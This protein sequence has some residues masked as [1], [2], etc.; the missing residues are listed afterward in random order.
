[1]VDRSE[2]AEGKVKEVAGKMTGNDELES[3][4]RT[5]KATEDTKENI[6]ELGDKVKGTAEGVKEKFQDR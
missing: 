5:Q 1:M 2:Q 6:E 3:E 4:G